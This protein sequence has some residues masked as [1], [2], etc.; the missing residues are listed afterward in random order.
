MPY[1]LVPEGYKL[2]KVNKEQKEAVNE[3]TQAQTFRRLAAAPNSGVIVVTALG[4]G[5]Y[6]LSKQLYIPDFRITDILL[7]LIPGV[8]VGQL[9]EKGA[10]NLQKLFDEGAGPDAATI[11]QI[12]FPTPEQREARKQESELR[13]YFPGG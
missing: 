10:A 12:I 6:F 3:F 2:Q 5:L 9:S 4:V 7:N 11:M 8:N 13:K 1:A